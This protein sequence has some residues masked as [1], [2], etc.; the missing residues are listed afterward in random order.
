MIKEI[1]NTWFSLLGEGYRK[2]DTVVFFEAGWKDAEEV[3]TS[4]EVFISTYYNRFWDSVN[5]EG[6]F[7]GLTKELC[8]MFY[9]EGWKS[10]LSYLYL[11]CL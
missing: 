2:K 1:H 9:D 10:S 3:K 4:S 8:K 6:A 7:H 5:D 11:R